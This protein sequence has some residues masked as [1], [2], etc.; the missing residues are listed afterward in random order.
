[1]NTRDQSIFGNYLYDRMVPPDHFLRLLNEIIEWEHFPQHLIE[2][3]QGGG[4]YGC[5]PFSPAQLL[6]MCLLPYFYDLSER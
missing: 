3:Y 1:M 4:E 5:P 6:K 2:L